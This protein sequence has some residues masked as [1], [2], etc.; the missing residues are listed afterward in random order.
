MV[1][2]LDWW[3]W[4][5]VHKE[6][7]S[8]HSHF[9]PTPRPIWYWA[10]TAGGE[11]QLWGKGEMGEM[12]GEDSAGDV[13]ADPVLEGGCSEGLRPVDNPSLESDIPEGLWPGGTQTEGRT[14][15]R[16][17]ILMGTHSGAEE[18]EETRSRGGE[19]AR[20]K[21]QKQESTVQ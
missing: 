19:R 3:L 2:G 1:E 16:D 17:C 11:Q 18:Q 6:A 5:P 20:R 7:V 14:P 9:Q 15:L 4:V 13:A 21:E 8:G 10:G 12:W